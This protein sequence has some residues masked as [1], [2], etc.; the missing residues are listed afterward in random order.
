[1]HDET[2]LL[3]DQARQVIDERVRRA[4]EAR[5]ARTLRGTRRHRLAQQLRSVAERLDT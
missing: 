1:V 3:P 5:T 4:S 2:T